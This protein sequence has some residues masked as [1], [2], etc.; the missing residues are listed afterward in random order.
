MSSSD[1]IVCSFYVR[2]TRQLSEHFT[3]STLQIATNN[4]PTYDVEPEIVSNTMIVEG[5]IENANNDEDVGSQQCAV[6]TSW[7]DLLKHK[8]ML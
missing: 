7:A 5:T 1:C 6:P 8:G 2:H 3:V 4:L